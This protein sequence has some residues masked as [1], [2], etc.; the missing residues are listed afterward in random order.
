[1]IQKSTLCKQTIYM[2]Y[3]DYYTPSPLF[4]PALC[5]SYVTFSDHL[6]LIK[7][8]LEEK[9][10][11]KSLKEEGKSLLVDMEWLLGSITHST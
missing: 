5:A 7:V 10:A 8:G 9:H 2:N 11:M 6:S 3:T 4:I 1:M